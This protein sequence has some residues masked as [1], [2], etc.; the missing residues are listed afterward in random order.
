M[1]AVNMVKTVATLTETCYRQVNPTANWQRKFGPTEFRGDF[2]FAQ[3]FWGEPPSMRKKSG[4]GRMAIRGRL[5]K[6]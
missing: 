3:A 2:C 4:V 6:T 5:C 1:N